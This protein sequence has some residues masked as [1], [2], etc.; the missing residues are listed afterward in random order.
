M[1]VASLWPE[2]PPCNDHIEHE[3]QKHFL[4]FIIKITSVEVTFV[5]I[6]SDFVLLQKYQFFSDTS[7]DI[8]TFFLH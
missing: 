4:V 1:L 8:C 3:K 6:L 5:K 2:K 7:C